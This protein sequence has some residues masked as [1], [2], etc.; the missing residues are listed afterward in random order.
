M[1]CS[2]A[3]SAFLFYYRHGEILLYGDAIAHINI[4]R[5]V[6]DSRT[7]GLL[8]LGTV[9]LPLPHLLMIPFL[10]S[11]AMWQTGAG[12][13]IPSLAAHV[14]GVLGIFRLTRSALSRTAH[15]DGAVRAAGWTAAL[16]Y[17]A[18]PN[19]IYL[20]TTAMG[21]SV[22]LAFF[23]WAVVFYTEWVR[24]DRKAVTK[25]ALCLAAGCLTRYDAWL[26]A[27]AMAVVAI[28]LFFQRSSRSARDW[29][30]ARSEL[31][32]FLA[33]VSA[34][35]A[36]WIAYNGVVYRNPLEFANGPYSAKAIELRTQSPQNTGHPG[37]GN[38]VL[39]GKYFLKAAEINI[40][41]NDWLARAW[42]LLACVALVGGVLASRRSNGE[43]MWPLVFLLVPLVFYTLAVAYGGVP[44]FVPSR[45]PFSHYN[46][47]Y[48]LQLLPAFAVALALIVYFALQTTRWNLRI[49]LAC[50][51]AVFV[52]IGGSYRSI[53]RATPVSLAEARLNMRTRNQ[54][55]FEVARWLEKLPPE[56]TILMYVG[57]QVGALERA[58]VPIKRTINEGNHRI[59]KRPADPQ[60]LWELALADPGKYADYVLAFDGDP[61]WQAVHDKDLHVLVELHVTGQPRAIL[62]QA[63]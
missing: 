12:G 37:T 28:A 6:F 39:A 56:S 43:R 21:E 62:Y 24:G 48:G 38:P 54:L 35:P 10:I 5:R 52:L 25:S 36:L 41:E 33:I 17:G 14:F 47:R 30:P 49:R 60:G 7:P 32:K 13:S 27:A 55:Q 44:I 58:A 19:L 50:V 42:V 4:A 11:N 45:W 1:A 18:N 23:V 40:A 9:W 46:V 31:I 29:W 2:T 20:Q 22:Y 3:V 59:W 63:R 26:L 8:Q 53:W 61:V 15:A 16:V 34:A 51:L 57:D